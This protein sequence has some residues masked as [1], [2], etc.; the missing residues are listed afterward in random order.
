VSN[1]AV[2]IDGLSFSYP[3]YYA[4][5]RNP[6]LKEITLSIPEGGL[7]VVLGK[8]DAGKTTLTRVLGGFAP[9]FTGGTFSGRARFRDT[10]LAGAKPYQL[11]ET[12]GFVFQDADE[13]I[14]TT[15]CDTE[16]A[17]ALESLGVGRTDMGRLVEGALDFAGLS[18]FAGR[19]PAT[20]SGGEKKRLLIACLK[21]IDPPL[22][23][24]DE[25]L[26][27]LDPAWKGKLLDFLHDSGKTALLLD[28]RW[29]PLYAHHDAGL[30][31]LREGQCT[32]EGAWVPPSRDAILAGE[33]LLAPVR[34]EPPRNGEPHP[35]LRCSRIEFGFPAPSSFSLHIEDLTIQEDSVCALVGRNGSGK[36]TLGRILCGLLVPQSGSVEW[37]GPQG[38]RADPEGLQRAVGYLFQN[39]DYQIF[40]PTV[41]EELSFGLRRQGV[42]Q[43]EVER[44]VQ[45]AIRVFRLPSEGTPP[46]LMGYGARKRLQAACYFLL[47]RRLLILDEADA[48]L[49]YTDF[50]SILEALRSRGASILLVTHDMLLAATAAERILVLDG[51]RI[52]SDTR[53]LPAG[54]PEAGG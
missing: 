27:E 9:R 19:H 41:G 33:G 47:E 35:L 5:Q 11:L 51:G 44:R 22:W 14:I 18:G 16:I 29:S 30:F 50:A 42:A 8:A 46:S 39:P 17:F 52:L 3:E 28:S 25:I 10:E 32:A 23:V 6:V 40:L 34:A 26:Q 4:G 36:S 1:P 21:A 7:G 13:Q 45:E 20:L 24:L 48:G 12:A 54:F 15:R 43:A 53:G 31:L 2:Q 38:L 49:C 37:A